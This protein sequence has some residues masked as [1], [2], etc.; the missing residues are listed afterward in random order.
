[1]ERALQCLCAHRCTARAP[2]YDVGMDSV[3]QGRKS[4]R[5]LTQPPADPTGSGPAVERAY[6]DESANPTPG[7]W[8]RLSYSPFIANVIVIRRCNLACGYCNEF[9]QTSAPVPADLLQARFAKLR[10]LGTF[11]ISL[12]GGEPTMHPDLPALVRACRAMG[13][14][15]VGMIT[16]GMLLKPRLIEALNEA[17]LHELQISIDGVQAND[18]TE[19]VL[20]NLKKRLAWLRDYAKFRV[21][22]SGVIGACPP[23]EAYE[24]VDYAIRMKFTPRV[25]LVHDESGRLK[26]D[27]EELA[28]FKRITRRIPRRWTDFTSYRD[29]LIR[30][31]TAPFK[32]RAGSR[33]LY[34]DENGLVS[35]CSQTR[36]SFSKPLSQYSM[37]DLQEQFYAY[38]SCQDAC[39]LGCVRSASQVD[40]WR[41]QNAPDQS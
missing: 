18:T 39:T 13:F 7:W 20:N 1:M 3:T 9:D 22:I 14:F 10:E 25:L 37:A 35:W 16:N 31:G 30:E 26:L 11:A 2:E 32:C 21:T 17:G 40:G 6:S 15:R 12:S 4:L 36:E 23:E 5:V 38:K 29:T 27:A 28:A 19:K 41:H 8:Q 34:V 33:Y 24:V